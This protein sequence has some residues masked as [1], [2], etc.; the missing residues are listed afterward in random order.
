M[1]NLN[2]A[3]NQVKMNLEEIINKLKKLQ[4]NLD[5]YYNINSNVIN[6][7]KKIKIEIIIC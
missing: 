6:N 5:M 1:D 2:S 3:I 7:Y 4:E